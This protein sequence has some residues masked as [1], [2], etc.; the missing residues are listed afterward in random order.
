MS[1]EKSGFIKSVGRF[2]VSTVISRILGLLREVSFAAVF[3][4]GGSMDAFVAAFRIPNLLRDLFAEGALSAAYVPVFTER[5]K[6]DSTQKAFLITSS[7]FSIIL[8]V[9]GLIVIFGIL[10]AP[11]YVKFY[12]SGFGA[13]AEA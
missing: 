8:V 11:Y 9:L 10:L 5:M 7:I 12:V 1:T 13:G 6:K 2:S 4:A 3:G